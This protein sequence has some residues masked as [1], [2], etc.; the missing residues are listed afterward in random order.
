MFAMVQRALSAGASSIGKAKQLIAGTTAAMRVTELKP[1]SDQ[2][3]SLIE[4]R[5]YTAGVYGD[6]NEVIALNRPPIEDIAVSIPKNEV[7]QLF[8]GLDF[9]I[10]EDELGNTK[11]LASEAW[12]LFIVIMGLALLAEAIFCLPPKPETDSIQLGGARS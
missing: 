3:V 8:E 4:S 11:S 5:P 12:K 9:H 1:L 10:I 7:N 6:E 2:R